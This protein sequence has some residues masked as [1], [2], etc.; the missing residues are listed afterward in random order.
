MTDMVSG[1]EEEGW[2]N[3]L[4]YSHIEKESD[5]WKLLEEQN[6]FDMELYEYAKYIFRE[7]SIFF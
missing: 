7:Q 2:A 4:E 5:T 1:S 6:A 3:Q